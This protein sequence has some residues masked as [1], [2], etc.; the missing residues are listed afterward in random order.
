MKRRHK[1]FLILLVLI[2]LG[3]WCFAQG[4]VTRSHTVNVSV[5]TLTYLSIT[6]SPVTITIDAANATAGEDAM[7]NTNSSTTLNWATN[8]SLRKVTVI[9]T[10]A[11]LPPYQLSVLAINIATLDQINGPAIAAPQVTLSLTA[12]DFLTN[13]GRSMGSCTPQYTLTALASAG[14]VS[15]NP[16][17]HLTFTIQAQ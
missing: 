1:I 11:A 3:S 12:A 15:P 8:S 4:R 7:T 17:E 14:I 16:T 2:S 13:I 9:V 6:G 5:N 10:D